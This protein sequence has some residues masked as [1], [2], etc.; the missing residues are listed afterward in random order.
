MASNLRPLAIAT[1]LLAGTYAVCGGDDE[2]ATRP[3]VEQQPVTTNLVAQMEADIDKR[4]VDTVAQIVGMYMRHERSDAGAR[5]CPGVGPMIEGGWLTDELLMDRWGHRLRT[6]C[7]YDDG[8]AR[9]QYLSAGADG[10]F[11]TADDIM[12]DPA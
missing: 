12:S 8:A 1:L 2:D 10:V 3:G 9:I 4:R 7:S 5:I 6:V 11:E